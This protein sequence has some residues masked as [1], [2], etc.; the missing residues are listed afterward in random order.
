MIAELMLKTGCSA[1]AATA[2]LTL[3]DGIMTF[4]IEYLERR[5][6]AKDMEIKERYPMWC[7]YVMQKRRV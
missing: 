7:Q 4:A 6:L 1:A 3:R 2:A 5:D